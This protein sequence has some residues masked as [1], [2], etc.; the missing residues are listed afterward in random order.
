M[1]WHSYRAVKSTVQVIGKR[2]I[3]G[4]NSLSKVP[5]GVA[6]EARDGTGEIGKKEVYD[7]SGCGSESWLVAEGDHRV[8]YG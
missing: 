8:A 5:V 6:L 1:H 4:C 3:L 2:R 7:G